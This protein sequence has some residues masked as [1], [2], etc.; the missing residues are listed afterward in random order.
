MRRRTVVLGAAAGAMLAAVG[1]RAQTALRRRVAVLIATDAKSTA[2]LFDAFAGRMR[3][4]GWV[5]GSNIEYVVRYAESRSATFG[6]LAGEL[7]AATPDVLFAPYGAAAVAAL[8]HGT[9]TPIVFALTTD[10]VGHGLVASL[11]RPGGTATGVSTRGDEVIAKRLELLRDIVPS[12]KRIGL[13]INEELATRFRTSLEVDGLKRAAERVGIDVVMERYNTR[14]DL[15]G[16]IDKLVRRR[17]DSLW[18]MPEQYGQR[19]ELVSHT[20]RARLPG[21]YNSSEYVEAGGLFSLAPS[22][23]GRYRQA[24]GYV[25]RILRGA[26]PGELPVEEA[27]T[28]EFTLNLKAARALG[29]KVPPAVL[30]RA[31]RVIE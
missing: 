17:V 3:E 23:P 20:M 22:F 19:A 27:S 6:P 24:A 9:P 26:K 2:H 12:V 7:L 16:A 31:D 4:L 11:A 5:E 15:G 29:L 25:D 1:V 10:P 14:E 28:L 13:L 18:G 30:L 8:R 21:S